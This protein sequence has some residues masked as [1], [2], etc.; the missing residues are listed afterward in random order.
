M[1]QLSSSNV[2]AH[3]ALDLIEAINSPQPATPF[4]H[5]G[6]KQMATLREFTAIFHSALVPAVEKQPTTPVILVLP[7]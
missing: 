1:P 5:I 6:N 4:P 3:A 7:Q 2:A